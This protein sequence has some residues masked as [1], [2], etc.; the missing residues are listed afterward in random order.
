MTFGQTTS[1]S[2]Q[3][4]GHVPVMSDV[5]SDEDLRKRALV[6][7]ALALHDGTYKGELE[8]AVDC[9]SMEMKAEYAE[10]LRICPRVAATESDPLMFLRRES[11]NYWAAALR[12][13]S[14]WKLRKDIF[15]GEA[16]SPLL[17]S[18]NLDYLESGV[19]RLLPPDKQGRSVLCFN[20]NSLDEFPLDLKAFRQACFY[21][22]SILA[23]DVRNQ[24]EGFI[25]ICLFSRKIP[26][27][28]Y[29][30]RD[31][32]DI[33]IKALPVKVSRILLVQ[34]SVTTLTGS[35]FSLEVVPCVARFV[36]S[37]LER[38]SVPI[39][40]ETLD[41]VKKG[42]RASGIPATTI[43][44]LISGE[45]VRLESDLASI[46]DEAAMSSHTFAP[47][48]S[49]LAPLSVQPCNHE[50]IR[51]AQ[52]EEVLRSLPQGEKAAFLEAS[53]TAPQLIDIETP[54][55]RFL[56]FEKM[57]P[58]AAARR[59]V[60]YWQM[61]KEVF[62]ERFCLPL[63]IASG[64]SALSDFDL[65]VLG[66]G[67]GAFVSCDQTGRAIILFNPSRADFV[68]DHDRFERI[69]AL[70]YVVQVASEFSSEA[71]TM[72]VFSIRGASPRSVQFYLD[73][74]ERGAPIRLVHSNICILSPKSGWRSYMQACV[75]R[76]MQG[77]PKHVLRNLTIHIAST[78]KDILGRLEAAGF[79]VH[80]LP[81]CLGGHWTCE[82]SFASWLQQR[83]QVDAIRYL[84][85]PKCMISVK[86]TDS[87][88]KAA[89][90]ARSRPDELGFLGLDA[91]G[92]SRDTS[93]PFEVRPRDFN[94]DHAIRVVS[95]RGTA[96]SESPPSHLHPTSPHEYSKEVPSMKRKRAQTDDRSARSFYQMALRRAPNLVD[97]ESPMDMF[98]RFTRENDR[99][100]ALES[101]EQYWTTRESLF[102]DR[103]FS[104]MNQTGEGALTQN[105]GKLLA[106]GFIV[107][108]QSD[109]AKRSVACISLSKLPVND[110][111][112]ASLQRVIF[113][114]GSV[115][116]ENPLTQSDGCVLLLHCHTHPRPGAVFHEIFRILL[117]ALPI[118]VHSV[119]LLGA[120]AFCGRQLFKSL[121]DE[122]IS[123]LNLHTK[124]QTV[125]HYCESESFLACQLERYGLV[126]TSLPECF[127]GKW[128]YNCL[129][130]WIDARIRFEW[131][132]PTRK[133]LHHG[134]APVPQHTVAPLSRCSQEEKQER[135]RR[136]HMLH[137]RRRRGRMRVE[138]DVL[139]VQVEELIQEQ[140]RLRET[141]VF[142]EAQMSSARRIIAKY[143]P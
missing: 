95:T 70:F 137:S 89:L 116:C 78:R 20:V 92:D 82:E 109:N 139:E 50:L 112:I 128:S 85:E 122:T 51:L 121:A 21:F 86:N 6:D 9:I 71:V 133:E 141:N 29:S 48:K 77:L 62:S 58:N 102:G 60:T 104:P 34:A 88:I 30:C 38:L 22:A 59:L 143:A 90:C 2:I 64:P 105:D 114:M 93:V 14:Y 43:A 136:L 31:I 1:N 81:D 54:Q 53:Q 107:L 39:F 118:H 45:D 131:G 37:A 83:T 110:L 35:E 106:E 26:E 69:R 63:S 129:S 96:R 132:L 44:Q 23:Q 33:T 108:L 61:R 84:H 55:I 99:S 49:V 19:F 46:D 3:A 56:R 17:A 94:V 103:A 97:K 111:Q 4:A 123:V 135:T 125:S 120:P 10:A 15:Q 130:D 16:F 140:V 67:A 41:Q 75:P 80:H 113:Y 138:V 117:T 12:L 13:A 72:T 76:L 8:K 100:R 42:L 91:S 47:R 5:E 101:L 115:L 52:M 126:P 24:C 74:M 68:G 119:H 73:F 40:G 25:L 142:L 98:L 11:F 36:G 28:C 127:G 32:L 79:L 18:S 87:L 65:K 124:A 57:N 66:S 7:Q 27:I 134:A